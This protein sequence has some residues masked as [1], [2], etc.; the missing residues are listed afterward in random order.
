[1]TPSLCIRQT[2]DKV[3]FVQRAV[4]KFLARRKKCIARRYWKCSGRFE[5]KWRPSWRRA[6]LRNA[7]ETL[8]GGCRGKRLQSATRMALAARLA[9]EEVTLVE[10]LDFESPKTSAMVATLNSLGM[11]GKTVLVS[12]DAHNGNLW[13]S[14]TF[15]ASLSR[16]LLTLSALS[17]LQPRAI[18]MTAAIDAFREETKRLRESSRTRSARKQGGRKSAKASTRSRTASQ[19]KQEGEA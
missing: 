16:R 11:A 15:R 3:H 7:R 17:I 12:S 4:E 10:S 6:Y 9:D 1:M 19:G 5:K 8:V 2:C 18:V 13:K 14:E